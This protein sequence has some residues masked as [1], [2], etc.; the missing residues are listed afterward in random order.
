MDENSWQ[1]TQLAESAIDAPSLSA[2]YGD[3]VW[4]GWAGTDGNGT[5]NVASGF[6]PGS[7]SSYDK[8][9]L[10]GNAGAFFQPQMPPAFHG[11]DSSPRGPQL[12][13]DDLSFTM[14]Y[15]GGDQHIYLLTAFAG[16]FNRY[17]CNDTS[18]VGVA[19]SGRAS[20]GGFAWRGL[21]GGFTLNTASNEF[22]EMGAVEAR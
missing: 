21:D 19:V 1:S 7:E 22:D 6:R 8:T 5:L 9:T 2:G 3:R 10:D 20:G 14:A 15:A 4:L 17:K 12:E 16:S 18:D 11:P 13:V